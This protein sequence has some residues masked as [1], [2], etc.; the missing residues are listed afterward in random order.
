[1]S[2]QPYRVTV[3]DWAS[4]QALSQPIRMEVF[5]QEQNVPAELEMDQ[6]DALC[7]HAIAFNAAGE[8]V[9]TGRLLPDG[10]IGRMAVRKVARGTG[11]GG[12]LLQALMAQAHARGDRV[13]ALSAQTHAAPFYQRHGF[14]VEGDEFYEA[15]IAHIN[16]V[17]RY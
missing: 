9:G 8:A 3:G 13:L 11:V 14:V 10:H 17:Y 16:M 2:E 6:M 7:L 15:G 4:Q 1:M 5:V 12:L